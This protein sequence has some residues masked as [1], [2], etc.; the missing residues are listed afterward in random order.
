MAAK[1]ATAKK[2]AVQS[3]TFK[4]MRRRGVSK[5]AAAKMASR[6]ARKC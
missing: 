1:K 5:G 6:A 3:K 4:A 2:K